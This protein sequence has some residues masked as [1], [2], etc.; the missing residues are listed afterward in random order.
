MKWQDIIGKTIKKT[1]TTFGINVVKITFTDDTSIVIDT[2]AIGRGL[3][4]P[5][6]FD[7]KSYSK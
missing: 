2:E 7:I 5:V 6:V 3:Y 4:V 1:N